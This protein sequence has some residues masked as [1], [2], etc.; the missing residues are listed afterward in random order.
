MPGGG[1]G[2][3]E[4]FTENQRNHRILSIMSSNPTGFSLH[5]FFA[6]DYFQKI[7]ERKAWGVKS[8][9]EFYSERRL[10]H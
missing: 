1:G 10:V 3:S 9:P 4:K 8:V 2:S 5:R 7:E 6:I